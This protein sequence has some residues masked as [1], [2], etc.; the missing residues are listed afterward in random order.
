MRGLSLLKDASDFD[1]T[2]PTL[3]KPPGASEDHEGDTTFVY[4]LDKNP[5]N[6]E[7]RQPTLTV[8]QKYERSFLPKVKKMCRYR[9]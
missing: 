3:V 6:P 7:G 8:V 1:P 4:R 2:A 5:D 9:S